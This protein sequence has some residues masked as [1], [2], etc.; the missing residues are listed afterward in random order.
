MTPVLSRPQ[1]LVTHAHPI[2]AFLVK[3]YPSPC[4]IT[5]I[6]PFF[7]EITIL[8]PFSYKT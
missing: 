3:N 1:L 4:K 7:S 2:F 5:H 8:Q 6:Y